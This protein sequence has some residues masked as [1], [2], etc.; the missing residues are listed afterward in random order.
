MKINRHKKYGTAIYMSI[1]CA[2]MAFSA[3]SCGFLPENEEETETVSVGKGSEI[4][5]E[6]NFGSGGS[7]KL[8]WSDEFDYSGV[9]DTSKWKYQTGKS[10]WGNNELQNYIDNT[11]EAKTAVV[12]DGVLK[13]KAYKE[14]GEWK[15][16]RM[17]SKQS[18][19][20]GFIEARMKITDK[21]GAWPAFWMMP[22]DSVYGSWPKSGEIDIMENAP[23]TQGQ[24]RVFS[25][26]HAEGHYGATPK[27]I[28]KKVI[29]NLANDWHSIAVKWDSEK[30]TAY[31][32]GVEQKSYYNN[33]KGYVDWPY[34][35]DFYIILNLAI[36]GNLG[37]T[38]DAASLASSGAEF[39]IDYV[40]VYQ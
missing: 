17:N 31:Y 29:D 23:S 10:G 27:S 35:Q 36:G 4:V 11:T 5:Q 39:L 21:K 40:R 6:I 25:S 2:L 34:D 18:W 32:D 7:M 14:N 22:Q 16:A 20:Y 1:F 8:V 30:I 38:S 33:G 19:T 12:E 9:P 15:S 28:G 3:G 37:G 13:I 24:G 26:L